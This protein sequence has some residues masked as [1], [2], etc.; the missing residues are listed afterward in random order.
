H[1]ADMKELYPVIETIVELVK[2]FKTL[3]TKEKRERAL[4][5][6]LD[7]EHLC[8]AV[9]TEEQDESGTYMLSHIAEGYK[10]TFKEILIDEYQDI[11]HVQETIL[12]LIS[13]D[14]GPGNRFM[15]GDVKQSI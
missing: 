6:F 4:V 12:S 15:V 13:D 1:L 11:N 2:H 7:L 9:F 14:I 8:L 10:E 3:F 5:D